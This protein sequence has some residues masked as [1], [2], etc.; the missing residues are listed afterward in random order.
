MV[1]K[2]VLPGHLYSSVEMCAQADR[3]DLAREAFARRV[4]PAAFT[5][6]AGCECY[7]QALLHWELAATHMRLAAEAEISTPRRA[8]E[9]EDS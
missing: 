4:K 9:Q 1:K 2:S 5:T 6:V 8:D 7:R 3:V